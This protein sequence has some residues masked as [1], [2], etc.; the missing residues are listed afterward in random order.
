MRKMKDKHPEKKKRNYF[1]SNRF[2]LYPKI[3]CV[4]PHERKKNNRGYVIRHAA[5][6]CC[7]RIDKSPKKWASNIICQRSK[8]VDNGLKGNSVMHLGCCIFKEVSKDNK[9]QDK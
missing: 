6:W 4:G 7:K 5:R 8:E 3:G 1:S 9:P 2:F